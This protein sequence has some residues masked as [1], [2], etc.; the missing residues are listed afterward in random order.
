MGGD[1]TM[2]AAVLY[3]TGKPLVIEEVEL[4]EPQENEILVK[5]EAT[6]VCHS[7]LNFMRGD[8]PQPLPFVPGH[9]GAGIVEKVGPGVTSVQPG[10]HVILMVLIACGKCGFCLSGRSTI[11]QENIMIQMT[12]A[13]PGGGIRLHKGDQPLHHLFGLA[14]FA[15]KVVVNECSAVKIRKDVPLD[16]A[17]LLGCGA[18]TGIGAAINTANA[19]PGDSIAIFG[20]GGV[21]MSAVMGAKATGAKVIALDTVDSKLEIAK[22]LGADHVINVTKEDPQ[23]KIREILGDGTDYAIEATGNADVILQALYC[24]RAGGLLVIAGMPAFEDT[25]NIPVAQFLIGKTMTASLQGDIVPPVDIPRYIDMF[26]D[27]NLP[28]DK[29]VT[30]TYP[31]DEVNEAFEAMEKGEVIRSV[32]KM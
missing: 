24:V 5:L 30:R 31:L 32:I 10:D 17:C 27:G 4:D 22:G 21:G 26:M 20:L 29:L 7:D 25:V 15:E 23:G 3:E 18:S 13:L 11:C 9:E 16:V 1:V 19:K 14:C 8:T 12:G 28:I 2:K 6:G